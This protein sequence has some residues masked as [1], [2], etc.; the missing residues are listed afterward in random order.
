MGIT[1]NGI[2]KAI[3]GSCYGRVETKG[4]NTGVLTQGVEAPQV[5]PPQYNKMCT[6]QMGDCVS[7]I[8]LG[9]PHVG[10]AAGTMAGV[11]SSGFEDGPSENWKLLANYVG[12]RGDRII[13]CPGPSHKTLGLKYILETAG[14]YF[15]KHRPNVRVI[16]CAYG[17]SSYLVT[18]RGEVT[19]DRSG[20]RAA[21]YNIVNIGESKWDPKDFVRL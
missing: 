19:E 14:G 11:H 4:N 16:Q 8:A 3:I 6:G 2:I 7:L 21:K 15:K 12:G 9:R 18:R 10:N 17:Y 20:V 13:I 1:L 5:L